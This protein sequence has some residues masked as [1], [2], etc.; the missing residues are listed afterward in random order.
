MR[1]DSDTLKVSLNNGIAQIEINRP[2]NN[3]DAPAYSVLFARA[4]LTRPLP[5]SNPSLAQLHDRFLDERLDRLGNTQT[6]YRAREFI[7]RKLPEGEPKREEIAS[8]LFMSERTLQRRLGDEGTSFHRLLDD[9][10]RELAQRYLRQRHL[11]LAEAAY[12]LGFADQSSF[13]RACK[14]WFDSSPGQYRARAD[15]V[16]SGRAAK[17]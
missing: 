10:R 5:T 4:D 1:M 14:R 13:S 6:S 17:A 7:M 3:S 8:A 15:S 9:T 11:S 12:L 2:E 16:Q